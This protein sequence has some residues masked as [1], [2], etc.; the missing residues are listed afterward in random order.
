[1][2]PALIVVVAITVGW[3]DPSLRVGRLMG[4]AGCFAFSRHGRVAFAAAHSGRIVAFGSTARAAARGASVRATRTLTE[5]ASVRPAR[6]LPRRALLFGTT[7]DDF[8]RFTWTAASLR[9]SLLALCTSA[10]FRTLLA[11]AEASAIGVRIERA[12]LSLSAVSLFLFGTCLSSTTL[13]W[14][15]A[16]I[17]TPLGAR[18][19]IIRPTAL[20]KLPVCAIN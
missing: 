12:R 16:A 1:M 13:V 2:T 8:G 11:Y 5:G 6:T 19:H 3:L 4:F 10:S 17:A 9:F 14:F 20:L 18:A 15:L 7:S